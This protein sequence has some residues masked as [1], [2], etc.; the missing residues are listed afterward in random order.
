MS[1]WMSKGFLMNPSAPAATSSP[2]S[3]RSM[4]P[5]MKIDLD[6]R[7]LVGRAD[8]RAH[9]VAVDVGQLVVQQHEVRLEARGQQTGV[10]ARAAELDLE[11]A[12]TA[13]Q[14]TEQL[15][16]LRV[17]INAQDALDLALE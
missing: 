1:S 6:V 5:E 4:T 9:L 10:V 14:I 8:A 17:V 15:D 7:Q 16:D 2:D 12:V 3:S 13:E 11:P